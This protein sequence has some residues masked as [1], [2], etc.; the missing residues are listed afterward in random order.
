MK[1]E[2]QECGMVNISYNIAEA[3][4]KAEEFTNEGE[5]IMMLYNLI[6]SVKK[7]IYKAKYISRCTIIICSIWV[8]LVVNNNIIITY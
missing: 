7:K 5:Y 3:L 6:E 2:M 1:N 8:Y 4:V